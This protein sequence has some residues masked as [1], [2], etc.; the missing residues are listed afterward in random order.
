MD[1]ASLSG[2]SVS[3]LLCVVFMDSPPTVANVGDTPFRIRFHLA[4]LKGLFCGDPASLDLKSLV[5]FLHQLPAFFHSGPDPL[6]EAFAQ[7]GLSLRSLSETQLDR[8][9]PL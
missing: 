4:D 8:S 5:G 9:D 2:T 7:T 3:E 1:A 6:L